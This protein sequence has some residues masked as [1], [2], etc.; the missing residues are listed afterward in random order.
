MENNVVNVPYI[1]HEGA[2]VRLER[3]NKRLWILAI[4]LIIALGLSNGAWIYYESQ[5]ETRT[6]L[7]QDIDTGD[8]DAMVIGIG[9]YNGTNKA[10]DN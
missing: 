6:E 2:M 4:T 1:A 8:G 5:Y 9:D 7:E 3:I 10:K